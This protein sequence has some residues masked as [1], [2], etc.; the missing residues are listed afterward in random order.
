MLKKQLSVTQKRKMK[1]KRKRLRFIRK[2]LFFL[3][4]VYFVWIVFPKLWVDDEQLPEEDN[5]PSSEMWKELSS[6]VYPNSLRELLKNNPE[7]REFVLDYPNKKDIHPTIDLSNEVVKGEIPLF[8]QWDQRWGYEIYGDEMMALTGCGPTC[9][10]MV[11]C[12]LSG[13]AEWNPYAVAQMAEQQGFYEKGAGSSWTLMSDGA[14]SMG[15]LVSSVIFDEEHIKQKLEEGYP[16]ICIMGPGDFTTTGHFIV[17]CGVDG[18][19]N[20]KVRDPNSKVRS[21]ETWKLRDIMSQI[22]NLWAYSYE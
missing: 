5:N 17:L 22:R 13:D 21:E 12:G 15:L 16:I 9:L 14:E 1:R 2:V 11:R 19:G 4:L 18:Q 7:T 10:S 3:I 6:E 20:I 8:L